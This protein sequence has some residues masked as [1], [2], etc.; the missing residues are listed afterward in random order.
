MSNAS[1]PK[2]HQ[3][4]LLKRPSW[5][6]CLLWQRRTCCDRS[7]AAFQRKAKI[8]YFLRF[9]SI[10]QSRPF[11][12]GACLEL[13]KNHS[14]INNVIICGHGK[15]RILMYTLSF[16]SFQWRVDGCFRNF[17]EWTME[18]TNLIFL[19]IIVKLIVDYK[20]KIEFKSEVMTT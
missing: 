4:N 18:F 20:K 9:L 16:D 12:Q 8:E 1:S 3:N 7:F 11:S 19:R 10:L 15:V 17:L 6:N 14:K 13:D 5:T 2:Y